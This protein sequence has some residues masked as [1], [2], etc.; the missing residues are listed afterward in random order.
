MLHKLSWQVSRLCLTSPGQK[1]GRRGKGGLGINLTLAGLG[2]R[3]QVDLRMDGTAR[4]CRGRKKQREPQI[5]VL[6]EVWGTDG[7]TRP[8]GQEAGTGIGLYQE[9]EEVRKGAQREESAIGTSMPERGRIQK[10]HRSSRTRGEQ[11]L[12]EDSVRKQSTKYWSWSLAITGSRDTSKCRG[13]P[14]LSTVCPRLF[15]Q[16]SFPL[17]SLTG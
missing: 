4:G 2:L 13:H 6:S 3:S 1:D 12:E 15:D 9:W 10:F 8:A 16:L 11:R 17:L 7:W 5:P 14:F